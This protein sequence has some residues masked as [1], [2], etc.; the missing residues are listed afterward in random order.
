MVCQNDSHKS[1]GQ[2]GPY[3]DL[4]ALTDHKDVLRRINGHPASGLAELL[5]EL[6]KG[7]IL[8]HLNLECFIFS[9]AVPHMGVQIPKCFRKM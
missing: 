3:M 1:L 5:S 7:R 9:K 8:I 4:N 2:P 6:E